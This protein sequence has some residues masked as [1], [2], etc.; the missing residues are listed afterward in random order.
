MYETAG[1]GVRGGGV[2]DGWRSAHMFTLSWILCFFPIEEEMVLWASGQ[3]LIL[4][5]MYLSC[6]PA[7]HA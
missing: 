3:T 2:N 6:V 7:Y 4:C 5:F 1:A